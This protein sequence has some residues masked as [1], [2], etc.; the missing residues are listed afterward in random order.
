MSSRGKVV[1]LDSA[2]ARRRIPNL[3]GVESCTHCLDDGV[4]IVGTETRSRP[5]PA[6]G[7]AEFEVAGPCPSCERGFRL[8][9]GGSPESRPP[10]GDKGF[11]RGRTELT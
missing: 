8:E 11:W 7:T 2:R 3:T 5:L 4:V 1:D 6:A 9:F 10:W